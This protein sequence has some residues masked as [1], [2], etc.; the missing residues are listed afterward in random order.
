MT[1]TITI[2]APTLTYDGAG[3]GPAAIEKPLTVLLGPVTLSGS[4]LGPPQ[5]SRFGFSVVRRSAPGSIPEVWDDAGKHWLPDS[6]ASTAA[7]VA[8]S[9]RDGDPAPWSGILVAGGATDAAGAPAFAKAHNGYPHYAIRGTFGTAGGPTV[10]GPPSPLFTF[11]G[12]ADRNLMV[13]GPGPDEK[14]EQAT[15]TRLLLLNTALQVIGG[16]VVDRDSPGAVVT[17]SN[18]AGANVV[19]R[20]DGGIELHPAA[21]HGVVISGDVETERLTYRPAGGGPKR[22]LT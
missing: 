2:P 1:P 20:A 16:M 8:L 21:G 9:Y 18:A 15:Q 4:A 14:P 13:I 7:P 19:L 17:V 22:T 6:P 5:L 3:A 11:A 12:A 10:T